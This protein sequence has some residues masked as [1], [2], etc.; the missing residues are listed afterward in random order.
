VTLPS[1]LQYKIL[2]E[3]SGKKPT[4]ADTIECRYRGTR[5]D[6][7]EFDNSQSSGQ[8]ATLRVSEVISAWREAFKLMPVGS[9]WQLFI[10]PELAYGHL[11]SGRIGPYETI[12]YEI[13]LVNVM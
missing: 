7:S 5:I 4:E 6:G 12:I 13:E 9:R 1:G 8:P 2:K 10:P 3:G 11:G